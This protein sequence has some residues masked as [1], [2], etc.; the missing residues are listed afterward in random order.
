MRLFIAIDI[1]DPVKTALA[2]LPR[3]F[4]GARWVN[5]AQMHV[6][7]RFIGETDRADEIQAAL[8]VVNS[9][10]LELA[11]AGVGRFPHSS[12]MPPRVLWAGLKAPDTLASL[13]ESIN[14]AL[15]PLRLPP[16]DLPFSPHVTLAR[17]PNASA[18]TVEAA[19]R[20]LALNANVSSAPFLVTAFTLYEST[21]T[22]SGPMY[23]PVAVYQLNH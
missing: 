19:Q 18:A 11:I 22:P 1:P 7:L 23:T 17:T 15:A 8:A 9:A 6:T 12:R 3:R 14:A 20:F 10:P 16:D 5:P 4:D 13:H 2:A 21:L